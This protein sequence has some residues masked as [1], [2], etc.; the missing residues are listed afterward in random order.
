MITGRKGDRAASPLWITGL[1]PPDSSPVA[2]PSQ[3]PTAPPSPTPQHRGWGDDLTP[4]VGIFRS[5]RMGTFQSQLT[6][7]PYRAARRAINEPDGPDIVEREAALWRRPGRCRRPPSS[8]NSRNASTNSSQ[9]SPR[10]GARNPWQRHTLRSHGMPPVHGCSGRRHFPCGPRLANKEERRR[11]NA[12]AGT[13]SLRH[14]PI[15]IA[16]GRHRKMQLDA[17]DCVPT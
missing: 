8:R 7:T 1:S 9:F 2:A 3:L 13:A 11:E 10:L 16:N 17:R 6:P 15:G 14:S 5:Q 12:R 4:S